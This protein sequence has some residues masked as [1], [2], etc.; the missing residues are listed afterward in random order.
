MC[1]GVYVRAFNI[2]YNLFFNIWNI[3]HEEV[4]LSEVAN[5]RKAW[6]KC[7]GLKVK[8]WL[9]YDQNFVA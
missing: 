8:T 7:Y 9:V 2:V 3:L 5:Y 1:V 4:G 6:K